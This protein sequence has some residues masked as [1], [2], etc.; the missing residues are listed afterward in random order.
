MKFYKKKQLINKILVIF[1]AKTASQILTH[2]LKKNY[3]KLFG[4]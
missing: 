3:I 4:S 2:K 1:K